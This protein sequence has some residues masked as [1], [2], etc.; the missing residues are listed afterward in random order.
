MIFYINQASESR[1]KFITLD[2]FQARYTQTVPII[3]TFSKES[4]NE[5]F[6]LEGEYKRFVMRVLNGDSKQD[7]V[8]MKDRGIFL[9]VNNGNLLALDKHSFPIRKQSPFICTATYMDGDGNDGFYVTLAEET[10]FMGETDFRL[11]SL[12]LTYKK[13]AFSPPA[14]GLAYYLRVIQDR[15]WQNVIIGQEKGSY[16]QYDGQCFLINKERREL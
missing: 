11:R 7:V 12:V 15:T 14:D 13:G 1:L 3:K 4:E 10:Q 5:Y 8:L 6:I 16:D 9:T 2:G